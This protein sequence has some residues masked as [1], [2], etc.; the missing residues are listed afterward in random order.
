[1][2]LADPG[3]LQKPELPGADAAAPAP[4]DTTRE[5]ILKEAGYEQTYHVDE[6]IT[7][8]CG[9]LKKPK[10]LGLGTGQPVAEHTRV[11]YTPTEKRSG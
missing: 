3:G 2:P 9:P 8:V 4:A 10:R 11:G 1:M 7:R 5:D 6:I